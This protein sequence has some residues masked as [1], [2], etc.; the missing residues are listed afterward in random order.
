M[1]STYG[2]RNK[3]TEIVNNS[4][5]GTKCHFLTPVECPNLEMEI[6]PEGIRN[7]GIEEISCQRAVKTVLPHFW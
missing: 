1:N 6:I 4:G 5:N 7:W 3:P 2:L